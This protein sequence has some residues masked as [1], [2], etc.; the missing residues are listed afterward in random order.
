MDYTFQ[1]EHELKQWTPLIHFQSGQSGATL[2]ATE[3]KPKLDRFLCKKYGKEIDRFKQ[4]GHDALNYKMSIR[5]Y[6]QRLIDL[7]PKTPYDIYYG[8]MGDKTETKQGVISDKVTMTITCFDPE[9]MKTIDRDLSEFF[10]VTNFGSMQDK[11]FGSFTLMDADLN[12]KQ[13]SEFLRKD[14]KAE[15]CYC[16][17][18]N[19]KEFKQIKTVYGIMKTGVNFRNYSRSLLFKFMHD[20]YGIGNEKAFLKTERMAPAV[21]TNKSLSGVRFN[22][23]KNSD[24]HHYV[25]ALL[26]V[27]DHMDFLSDAYNKRDKTKVKVK[28]TNKEIERSGSPVFFKVIGRKVYFV[29]RRLNEE[30]Y[31]KSFI[32]ESKPGEESAFRPKKNAERLTVPD[33]EV[34]GEDFIDRFLEYAVAEL[35]RSE[36]AKFQDTLELKIEEV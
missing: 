9:L 10:V 4:P 22:D 17:T 15:K 34:L 31:G 30:I 5:C 2:R 13:I 1:K 21:V 12:D 16:F 20:S 27:G 7:G 19:G 32:F 18:H 35:N 14:A 23:Q 26:G 28:I 36:L 3:V 33:K 11:G 29:G 6:D 24:P 8:N 25:R